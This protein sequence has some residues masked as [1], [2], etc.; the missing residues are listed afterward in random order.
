MNI[1]MVG[2]AFPLRGGI[3][4]YNALLYRELS[5]RHSVQIITF[6]RQYPS[7]LFPGKTQSETS[8][9]LL[10]VPS[11]SLVDSVNPLNWIAV[12]R[13]IRKR[14]PDLIIFKYW[15][16]FFGPCFGTIARVAK[17]GTQTRVLFICD[18]IIPHEKRP[19]DR[20]FTRYAFSSADYFIVQSN[21]V[22]QDLLGFWPQARYRKAAH[23]VYNIFGNPIDKT[24]ARRRLAITAERVIL[25]FGYIRKYKGLHVLLDAMTELKESGNVHLLA[26]GECYDDEER[27]RE[28]IKALEL[29]K[30][31]TLQ[32]D[33][34]PN[35]R[36]G[37]YFSAADAVVLPYLSATQSGIAQIAY[38][39][40]KP[41]IATRVGGLAEVVVDGETGLLVPPGDAHALAR[42]IKQFYED[43]CETSFTFNVQLEKKK[44]TWEAMVN[45]IEDLASQ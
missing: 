23:P 6:K 30:H 26:V 1:I 29:E 31:V 17:H 12:G 18:N 42:A 35:D 38:N 43:G 34:I 33:Y 28:Q 4:H 3:A 44:Y 20:A 15:L 25:F 8:G 21:A 9:E 10:R 36:V 27:Y 19:G 32:T 24:E 45:A 13:E 2:T 11:R 41:V 14:R 40:D 37:L 7:I 39:F 16:P 22:E 5:K